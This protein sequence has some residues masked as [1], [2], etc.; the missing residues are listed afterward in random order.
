MVMK[1]QNC[2]DFA[3]EINFRRVLRP[4][5]PMGSCAARNVQNFGFNV[6]C[7]DGLVCSTSNIV[8]PVVAILADDG[9]EKSG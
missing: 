5:N 4:Q 1:F 6:A 3:F 8:L 7:R 2:H 9:T